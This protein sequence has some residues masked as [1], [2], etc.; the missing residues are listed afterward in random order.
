[1]CFAVSP[2]TSDLRAPSVMTAPLNARM[3]GLIGLLF[4]T[5]GCANSLPE[6]KRQAPPSAAV[7]RVSK[8]PPRACAN[9]PTHGGQAHA[10]LLMIFDNVAD[11]NAAIRTDSAQ[12]K[13]EPVQDPCA[14][15]SG[16]EWSEYH[17]PEVN[18]YYSCIGGHL[19]ASRRS[20]EGDSQEKE[21]YLQARGHFAV[22]FLAKADFSC[23][24][25]PEAHCYS[26]E[27]PAPL[28]CESDFS[29]RCTPEGQEG[30]L[31]VLDLARRVV[32]RLDDV[33]H[34]KTWNSSVQPDDRLRLTL[35][36]CVVDL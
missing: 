14:A 22:A 26:Q 20:K 34:V 9:R 35:D 5:C 11:L 24:G 10:E 4:L 32:H 29:L 36:D 17:A 21:L 18:W 6:L 31:E 16:A 19:V 25:K 15:N 12:T 30:I 7:S 27:A 3:T 2:M 28:F 23:P 8:L 33:R 1:V 13:G